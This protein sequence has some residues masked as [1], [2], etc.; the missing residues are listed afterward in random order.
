MARKQNPPKPI[1]W[2]VY[3]IASKAVL[4][5]DVEAPDEAGA[6]EKPAAEFGDEP[7]QECKWPHHVALPAK[8]CRAA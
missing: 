7:P 1:S 2:N 6:I 5:G 8:G 4:L 3:K